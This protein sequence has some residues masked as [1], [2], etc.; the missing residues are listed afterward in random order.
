MEQRIGVVITI[1]DGLIRRTRLY[2]K[3]EDALEAVGLRAEERK[4]GAQ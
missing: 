1:E 2:R 3:P 4:G